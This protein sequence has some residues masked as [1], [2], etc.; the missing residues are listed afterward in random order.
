[1]SFF[2]LLVVTMSSLSLIACATPDY[3]RNT[4]IPQPDH[5]QAYNLAKSAGFKNVK[6]IELP[7]DQYMKLNSQQDF[8][9]SNTGAYVSAGAFAYNPGLFSSLDVTMLGL[10]T[11]VSL[12]KPDQA[13]TGNWMFGWVDGPLDPLLYISDV[14]NQGI[15]SVKK[16]IESDLKLVPTID[17]NHLNSTA[18]FSSTGLVIPTSDNANCINEDFQNTCSFAFRYYTVPSDIYG[19]NFTGIIK[20]DTICID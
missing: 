12:M 1:M 6:D 4:H 18:S 20:R 11:L 3:R 17:Y 2:K 5:S 13:E 8:S 14:T 7:E 15:E 10:G 9:E 16:S 19:E